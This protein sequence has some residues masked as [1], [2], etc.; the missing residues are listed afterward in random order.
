[1]EK[2]LLIVDDEARLTE[3]FK[4]IFET[5]GFFVRTSSNAL[6]A[7]EIFKKNPFKVVL[8]DIQM[9]KMNGI[10]LMHALKQID[11]CVQIIFLT[12]YASVE[13]AANALKQNNAFEY[14]E[15]PV[16]NMDVI[17]ETIERAEKRYDLE[18]HLVTRKKKTE[19]G[20]A[21]FKDIFDSMEAAVYVSDMQ[22]HELIYAN[23]KLIKSFGY[24][25]LKAIEGQK[26]WQAVQKGQEGPCP[27]CTNKRLLQPDGSPGEP[28]EWEF[29]NTRNLR[30]YSIVDKAVKWYD[31]RIVRL[32]TA[33]DIT[34]KK[35]HEKLFREFEK[36]IETSKKLESIGTLAGGVA[37]DFNNTLSTIIGNINLAQL[38]CPDDETQKYLRVAE[39][40]VMQA[41]SISSKLISFARGGRP[42]KKETNIE[43]LIRQILES[44]LDPEKI[45]FSFE[46]DRI[47][48]SFYADPDQLKI[49]IE[50]MLQN[51]V[52]SMD[53]HGRINVSA[54]YLEQPP[55]TP[56]IFISISDSGCGIPRENLDMIF[57]PYFTTKPL[58]S[59]K[60]KGLGLS[61]AW[62]II[63]R[64]GGK[65][66]VESTLEEGT[67][68]HIFLPA[69]NKQG[70]EN[71]GGKNHK[72]R[73]RAASLLYKD[74]IRVL[75]MDDDELI[76]DVISKL[77]RRLGYEP[78]AASN[79]SQAIEICKKAAACGRKID[80]ALLDYD[81]QNDLG[82]FPTL[83]QLQKTDPDIRGLL[84]TGHCD[85]MEI[86]KFK[87]YG[88]VDMLEKPFSIKH[89]NNKIRKLLA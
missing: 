40:G 9:D 20:F 22:T 7:I 78:F 70:L 26:C 48:G 28:Y 85:D 34:G 23:K 46:P 63:S 37:H 38:N 80:I 4:I 44:R 77:L 71:N 56:G 81:I 47:S 39:Q 60:S 2:R 74:I 72:P 45:T 58:D 76:L 11:P 55:R 14:L 16:R 53:G 8:S 41:K 51:S 18:T 33:F 87:H 43:E 67:T 30:W 3:S 42:L 49:A 86:K 15:K 5:K 21:I 32:E 36:A 57:N 68:V 17:Y 50:N 19:K 27:F 12:G 1:M 82:G 54:R 65:I 64:H 84:I 66:N 52:E 88:F 24:D 59:R 6:D 10:E 83:E 69:F 25:D 31:K 35:E 79:G 89:L 75:V 29:R 13:N 73:A 62:S 61:V